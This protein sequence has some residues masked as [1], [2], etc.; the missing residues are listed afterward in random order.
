MLLFTTQN[1][2]SARSCT[3]PSARQ[4]LSWAWAGKAVSH[5]GRDSVR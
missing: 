3:M 4:A 5:L 1:Q 2:P